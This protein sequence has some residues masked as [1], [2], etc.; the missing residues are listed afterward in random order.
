MAYSPLLVATTYKVTP[1]ASQLC[2]LIRQNQ[3][4]R[5][6]YFELYLELVNRGSYNVDREDVL[7][8]DGFDDG[9]CWYLTIDYIL[10]I[11]EQHND[12]LERSLITKNISS[13]LFNKP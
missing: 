10:N 5:I 12:S 6:S 4:A 1:P 13:T 3:S 7:C 8:H 11:K 9:R 2:S